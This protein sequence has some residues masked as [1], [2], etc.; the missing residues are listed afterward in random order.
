MRDA[1]AGPLFGRDAELRQIETLATSAVAGQG[2]AVLI[3]GEGGIGKTRLVDHALA[4]A[5]QTG[6]TRRR[7][8]AVEFDVRR[9]FQAIATALG[10]APD[11]ADPELRELAGL[12]AGDQAVQTEPRL[13]EAMVAV[14]EKLCAAGPV[15]LAIDDL[16]WADAST[17]RVLDRLGRAAAQL[18]LLVCGAFRPAPRPPEL[19][20]LLRAHALRS[21]VTLELQPLQTPDIKR[22]LSSLLAVAP[23]PRLVAQAGAT[24][25]NQFYVTE[26]VA[27]LQATGALTATATTAEVDGLDH[28][29]ALR[30]TV[31]LELAHL[32]KD[33][34][35]V[36]RTASVLGSRFTV[37]DLALVL[38]LTP[39]ALAPRLGDAI[40]ARVLVDDGPALAF[41][42]DLLRD[43][44][45]EDVPV[46]LR[47]SLH[48][49]V[50]HTL[51]GA[52]AAPLELAEHFIRGASPGDA[53]ALDW[54]QRAAS[55]ATVQS[56]AIA[57][58]LL[59]RAAE[60]FDPADPGRDALLADWTIS[61]E[62]L[63]RVR[64]A[65]AMCA[66]LLG[67][68]QPAVTE[69]KLRLCLARMLIRRGQSEDA[70]LE[71]TRAEQVEGL[72][73]AQRARVLV[74]SSQ[75][76]LLSLK[77][78]L[79]EAEDRARRGQQMA[80][81]HGDEVS[82]ATAD[83]TLALV[84]FARGR[85]RKSVELAA[86]ARVTGEGPAGTRVYRGGQ[87]VH[88]YALL[89]LAQAW[90]NLDRVPEGR[91]AARAS[92]R[93]AIDLG[94]ESFAMHAAGVIVW[95]E[96]VLGSWDDATTEFDAL[97][98]LSAEVEERS[99]FV[100]LAAGA[101]ALIALHRGQHEV[102]AAVLATIEGAGAITAHVPALARARLAEST[103]DTAGALAA[104]S[105]AWE[106]AT[107]S[108][109]VSVLQHLAPDLVRLARVHGDHQRASEACEPIA[110]MAAAN[111]GAVTLCG[112]ELH[113]RGLRD[114]DPAVLVE[115]ATILRESCRPVER[116][117]ACEDAGEAL[118]RTGEVA[119]AQQW[120]DEAL[121]VYQLLEATW[122]QSRVAARLRAL[123]IRRASHDPRKRPK[124]GWEALTRSERA[125]VELV[126][127]GL[128]NPEVAE[129]LYLSRHTVKR[130]LANAMLKLDI[131]S[132]RELRI[133]SRSGV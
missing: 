32:P 51:A 43:A 132:R 109:V 117:R 104:L 103:G 120:F 95:N 63:G 6:T 42:H 121:A 111:P 4:A 123:G 80:R 97:L 14:V 81:Q 48:L 22:L 118:V 94:I 7:A 96:F 30:L 67:R 105:D 20:R 102:A 89:I 116:A 57:A 62:A 41:R 133:P 19:A 131:T 74:T 69:A 23:G 124:H 92:R 18:P 82:L 21:G 65:E 64:E 15:V 83:F 28:P 26:L 100:A 90:L 35:H 68:R 3:C 44:I 84:S 12:L 53:T 79:V 1:A 58:E 72:D 33:T 36:L 59:E 13:V 75:L 113:C 110:Q 46:A 85:F 2:A 27:A 5:T 37:G 112:I 98:D 114:D 17:L 29:P 70:A 25:G 77:T 39:V 9:P 45:Y 119:H 8:R 50:A 129:R 54:L 16:H 47:K 91:A 66:E 49:H 107:R 108:G 61:I 86:R 78:D 11:A 52:G 34:Q 127:E 99:Q 38:S 87:T 126:A 56:P 10:I 55:Q 31:L 24:G 130:H 115:A 128:S 106:Q 125:V 73:P 122:D 93:A 60:L 71:C 76:P 40:D 88:Q 101:R